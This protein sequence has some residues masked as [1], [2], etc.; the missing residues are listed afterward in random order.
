MDPA[1]EL[2]LMGAV[3]DSLEA[4]VAVL[5]AE[6]QILAVNEPWRDFARQNGVVQLA[7]TVE[8][9]NYLEVTR[10][11]AGEGA[12]FAGEVLAGLEEVLAG[13]R[14]SWTAEYNCDAPD[15][16]RWFTMKVRRLAS[17]DGRVVVVHENITPQKTIEIALRESEA[18]SR[19]AQ[20]AAR[21]GLWQWDL[22]TGRLAWSEEF[23]KLFGLDPGRD[24][25][26]FDTWRRVVHPEDLGAAEAN[27]NQAVASGELLDNRYRIL[28]PNGDSRW[29]RAV[30]SVVRDDAG[31]AVGMA[32]I[33][34]DISESKRAQV[35]AQLMLRTALDGVWLLSSEGVLL[36]ANEAAGT[37][38]G[39]SREE[40]VGKSIGDLEA[41]ESPEETRRHIERVNRQGADL[42]ESAHRRKDGSVVPVEIS[43]TLLPEVRQQVVY[44]RDIS[45][46]KR[47]EAAL[48]ARERH[49]Q[50]LVRLARRLGVAE[51]YQAAIQAAWDSVH[52]VLGYRN[53]WAYLLSADGT[54]FKS[55]AALGPVSAAVLSE[56]GTATLPI[57]GDRM[58]EEIAAARDIVV[59]EDARTDPRTDKA[60]VEA[61]G[62][63]TIVNIPILL[64]GESLGTIGTGTFGDE[65]VRIPDPLEREFLMSLA[66][67]LGA[68]FDRLRMLLERQ[69]VEENLRNAL[70]AVENSPAGI[71]VTD[72]DG[73]IQYANPAL[74]R[75]TGYA[76]PELLGMNAVDLNAGDQGEATIEAMWAQLRAGATW[77]GR[78]HN[79]R[80]DG[81][82]YWERA[83]I[84]PVFDEEGSISSFVG[85]KEDLTEP[86][87][88]EDERRTLEQQ[89]A[90]TQKL[91]S[92]GSLA[93]GV[94]HDMNNV[95]AAIMALASLHHRLAPPASSVHQAMDTIIKAC[96]RGGAL[97]KGLLGFARQGLGEVR[98]LDLN[99]LVVEEV[100]LLKHTTLQ[101]VQLEMDLE[102]GLRPIQGDP[103]PLS[104]ALMNLCVNAVD[105]MPNGGILTLRTRNA[106]GMVEVLVTDTGCGMS[107]TV[108]EKALEPFFTTKAEGKGTGL[109]LSIVYGTVKAHR[110]RMDLQSAPGAG[111]TVTLSFPASEPKQE[112]LTRRTEVGSRN[113]GMQIL[114]IDDD[115]LLLESLKQLLEALG[116]VPTMVGRG[117][118]GLGKL[119]EGF[120]PDAVILDWNMPGLG[121]A[122]T[123]PRIRGLRPLLPVILATGRA[124]EDARA[125]CARFPG[126][127]L[128]HK[129]FTLEELERLLE[130][131]AR[132]RP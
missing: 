80:K 68:S 96:E 55:V 102:D 62:N 15:E 27:I 52:Q 48:V 101:R 33:C 20:E 66:N 38:L 41:L 83:T 93:G 23:F 59:V 64:L 116:H 111:T 87:R 112:A 88:L 9:V 85:I 22:D 25:A 100:A 3:L 131:I 122:G 118:E 75:T 128:V 31:R 84:S 109:G 78:F 71:I 50:A 46:R 58:L 76:L 115:E 26:T 86:L 72:P 18:R 73:R 129:P 57:Q 8:A 2:A 97:V 14:D 98:Q 82:T 11:A 108:V 74:V 126:I 12:A 1:A 77:S 13:A 47:T 4:H 54:A 17:A 117:E 32:G 49:S 56:S 105:A 37:M 63:R 119:E 10:R 6:G 110:G 44:I 19:L 61:L 36:E 130:A 132:R 90:R 67:Q 53:L 106:G 70:A 113:P 51:S 65:G 39:Y 21:A 30:G 91:E 103:G 127:T 60:I 69:Q 5:D 123:L 45:R 42:F 114:V 104:H 43:V 125:M 99:A 107:T 7:G 124:D 16:I 95:L 29:I 34:L 79:R 120:A 24:E 28:L 121:G 94:A 40:L 92:L 35:Q 89:L 81:T